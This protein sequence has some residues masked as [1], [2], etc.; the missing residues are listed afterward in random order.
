MR[1]PRRSLKNPPELILKLSRRAVLLGAAVAPLLLRSAPASAAAASATPFSVYPQLGHR[2]QVNAV[3][4][5]PDGRMIV[6]GGKEDRLLKLWDVASGRMLRT[7]EGGYGRGVA[8]SPDGLSIAA[9]GEDDTLNLWDVTSGR[10]LHAFAGH[11]DLVQAVAFSPDGRT[12]ASA[13]K[14]ST[15]RLW[16]VSSGQELRRFEGSW[17]EFSP[18]GR[19]IIVSAGDDVRLWDLSSGQEL[20]RFEGG[21]PAVFSPDGRSIISENRQHN[22]TLILWDAASGQE[23]RTF[24]GR[25][26]LEFSPDGRGIVCFDRYGAEMKLRSV[27]DGEVLRTFKISWLTTVAFSPDRRSILIADQDG[28]RLWDVASGEVLRSFA[29]CGAK[30]SSLAAFS[31][32]GRSIVAGN[33]VPGNVPGP[34]EPGPLN[35]TSEGN[36]AVAFWDVATGRCSRTFE[37]PARPGCDASKVVAVVFRPSGNIF[38]WTTDSGDTCTSGTDIRTFRLWNVRSGRKLRTIRVRRRPLAFSADGRSILLEADSDVVL[39]DTAT[40]RVR[41]TFHLH[42]N[43]GAVLSSDGR[44]FATADIED[45]C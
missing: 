4:F 29:G 40:R 22:G 38:A 9:A 19:S 39:W 24:E 44:L 35:A 10:K 45:C 17:A 6:S 21:S 1:P 36:S 11:K 20:R 13:A 14:D 8:F 16:H 41:R 7:F 43:R 3:A 2:G 5:S 30:L 12:I 15:V 31:P 27:A 23:L 25:A 28:L 37:A 26:P 32:D 33:P 42:Y 34:G 18:D